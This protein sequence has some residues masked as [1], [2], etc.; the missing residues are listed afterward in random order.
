FA[1]KQGPDR[2]SIYREWGLLLK[3]SG[4]RNAPREAAP[5]L[6]EALKETPADHSCRNAIGECYVHI[7]SFQAAIEVLEPIRR[8][9]HLQPD[10]RRAALRLLE[11]CYRSTA[12]LIKLAEV[13]NEMQEL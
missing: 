3:A 12:D 5:K 9:L 6:V 11:Q 13:R 10:L 1:P 7:G 8:V 2:A 4:S